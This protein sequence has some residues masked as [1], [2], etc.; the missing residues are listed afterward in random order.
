[1]DKSDFYA[2]TH[3]VLGAATPFFPVILPL[4]IAYQFAQYQAK[5][6]TFP[7]E[8]RAE[9]G[10][11]LQHTMTKLGQYNTGL[12]ITGALLFAQRLM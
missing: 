6:R 12:F 1:M 10:N 4:F 5:I 8:L 3:I 11:S 7:M 9:G 2:I